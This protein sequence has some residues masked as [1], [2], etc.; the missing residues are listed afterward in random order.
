M[1]KYSCPQCY[2]KNRYYQQ[3]LSSGLFMPINEI[4]IFAKDL[5][6]YTAH[7]ARSHDLIQNLEENLGRQLSREEFLRV[8]IQITVFISISV[9]YILS[10]FS[11]DKID[12]GKKNAFLTLYGAET[13]D[14]FQ[15][16]GEW[17]DE[18]LEIYENLAENVGKIFKQSLKAKTTPKTIDYERLWANFAITLLRNLNLGTQISVGSE[19]LTPL[20]NS[21]QLNLATLS[22]EITKKLGEKL[23]LLEK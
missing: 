6:S 14:L 11:P 16:L 22:N 10:S 4:G 23:E 8:K 5:A 20:A 21:V 9:V 2:N 15:T 12:P 1:K 19:Q 18:D 17:S 3:L 13:K 7:S